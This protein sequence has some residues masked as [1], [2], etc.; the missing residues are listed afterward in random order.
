MNSPLRPLL[1][2]IATLAPLAFDYLELTM[3]APY[4][5]YSVLRKDCQ[6]VQA[7]LAQASMGLVCH[8]PT[9]VSLADLTDTIRDASIEETIQ[10]MHVAAELG[11]EK[12]VLHPW[13]VNGLG[14]MLPDF[15]RKL[16]R[17]AL[18]SILDAARELHLPI[19]LENLFP[20]AASLVQPDDFAEI[21]K[22]YP[23]LQLTLDTGHANIGGGNRRIIEFLTRYQNNIGHLHVS[24]NNG[25]S[26]D[27]L[28]I[29]AGRIDF[30]AITKKL[31]EIGYNATATFEIFTPDREYLR[32]SR[33]KFKA[34]LSC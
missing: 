26:D 9:F 14:S 32:L 30:A 34:L 11:A 3:D 21:F 33:E 13:F 31:H 4:A 15:S 8:L 5:H 20:R 29:G 2:E 18:N 16:G 6:K 7:A 19:C 22:E 10:S 17:E 27:H 25:R 23:D 24:D 28:P 1:D 12:A